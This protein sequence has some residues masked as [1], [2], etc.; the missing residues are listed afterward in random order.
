MHPSRWSGD[1]PYPLNECYLNR[2][3]SNVNRGGADT[4]GTCAYKGTSWTRLC[5]CKVDSKV[6]ALRVADGAVLWT[7]DDGGSYGGTQPSISADGK[8]LYYNA[9][10]LGSLRALDIADGQ[11]KWQ[12][13][14]YNYDSK[15]NVVSLDGG[16]CMLPCCF[17]FLCFLFY[18]HPP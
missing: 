14:A 16:M 10:A 15:S 3:D 11:L 13:S 7:H 5:P 2:D 6:R 17:G 4:F 1:H 9:P 18:S 8:T 12:V